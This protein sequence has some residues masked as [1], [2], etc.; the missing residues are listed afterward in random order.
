MYDKF[1][2]TKREVLLVASKFRGMYEWI[3]SQG[4]EFNIISDSNPV[5]DTIPRVKL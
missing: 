2:M 3:T 4:I 1:N 5:C